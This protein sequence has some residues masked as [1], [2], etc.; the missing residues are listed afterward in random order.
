VVRTEVALVGATGRRLRFAVRS[1]VWMR[2]ADE[3][4]IASYVASGEP[5]DKAG[6]HALQGEGGRLIDTYEG[7]CANI[8]GLPLCHAYFALRRMGVVTASLPEPA[9]ERGFHFTCP[10]WRCAYA[11][12]RG[13]RDGAEY[14]SWRRM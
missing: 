13:L 2:E 14:E 7:C 11:Q 4:R 9:F 1:R 8:I 6:A 12:G 3:R 5:L 10:A